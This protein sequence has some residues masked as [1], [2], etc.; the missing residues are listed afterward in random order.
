MQESWGEL[1]DGQAFQGQQWRERE[2]R[3]RANPSLKKGRGIYTPPGN[4]AIAVLQGRIFRSKF[5]PDILPYPQKTAKDFAH[6][7][8]IWGRIFRPDIS[9]LGRIIRPPLKMAK[10]QKLA[11][12]VSLR[13]KAGYFKTGSD[14]LPRK[15]EQYE[16]NDNF[17]IRTLFS[18]ILG[19]LE[20]PQ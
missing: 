12:C 9:K 3:K 14:N 13:F 10:D 20:S 15:S 1:R 6:I 17:C 19:S 8:Q 16:N 18:M 5:G 7:V 2:R 11:K 4:V